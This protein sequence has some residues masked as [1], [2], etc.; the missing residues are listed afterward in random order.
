[1][2]RAVRIAEVFSDLVRG[3]RPRPDI[4][5]TDRAGHHTIG[6]RHI[7]LQSALAEEYGQL[8]DY[9]IAELVEAFYQ[10]PFH[11]LGFPE[12]KHGTSKMG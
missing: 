1:L 2:E 7:E 12:F 6:A 4:R 10:L 5:I 3:D 9:K 8:Y 11:T